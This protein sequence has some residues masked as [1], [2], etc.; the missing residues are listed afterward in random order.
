MSKWETYEPYNS[1]TQTLQASAR[2]E[3]ER[4]EALDLLEDICRESPASSHHPLS[5]YL[6][7]A[8]AL[9]DRLRVEE[10]AIVDNQTMTL[11]NGDTVMASGIDEAVVI[12]SANN[13]RLGVRMVPQHAP[14]QPTV[15]EKVD[16]MEEMFWWQI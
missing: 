5:G 2:Y 3:H 1:L 12:D 7:D 10:K 13:E 11:H 15:R 16:R 14:K 6:L 8:R 9:F 4:N